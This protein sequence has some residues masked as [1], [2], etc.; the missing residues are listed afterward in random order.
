MHRQ[1][2]KLAQP[3]ASFSRRP[4]GL[5]SA[6]SH[7]KKGPS[8]APRFDWLAT[9]PC[10]LK[11]SVDHDVLPRPS[12]AV[13]LLGGGA[14]AIGALADAAT[15]PSPAWRKEQRAQALMQAHVQPGQ[16]AGTRRQRAARLRGPRAAATVPGEPVDY[17]RYEAARLLSW[18]ATTSSTSS[19]TAR[20]SRAPPP[21][22]SRRSLARRTWRLSCTRRAPGRLVLG[23][24]EGG[25][26][27]RDRVHQGRPR[28][29]A[30]PRA[31]QT[32]SATRSPHAV[33][34]ATPQSVVCRRDDI[35]GM[36]MP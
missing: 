32:T 21:S 33:P 31:P 16:P 36:S 7:P 13:G 24:R 1:K 23:R 6:R 14:V 34:T 2:C 26:R 25:H 5:S 15:Q 9:P 20:R 22:A 3:P 18:S 4:P 19:S 12:G 27:H 11:S 28:R 29:R 8:V 35:L 30:P 10:I 17:L